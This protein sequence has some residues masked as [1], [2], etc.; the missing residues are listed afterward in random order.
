MPFSE[1]KHLL[2]DG[3]VARYRHKIWLGPG[4]ESKKAEE[5]RMALNYCMLKVHMKELYSLQ[6][7]IIQD[8][9]S[10]SGGAPEEPI[11]FFVP[12]ILIPFILSLT[13]FNLDCSN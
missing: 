7:H 1:K 10:F 9:S 12:D 4:K 11:R 5:A 2:D 13:D 6:F 3:R 8:C